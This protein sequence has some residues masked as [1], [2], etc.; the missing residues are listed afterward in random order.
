[1]LCIQFF[2]TTQRSPIPWPHQRSSSPQPPPSPPFKDPGSDSGLGGSGVSVETQT[3]PH[4]SQTMETQT[5]PG[6]PLS[7]VS[8]E[9]TQLHIDPVPT[10]ALVSLEVQTE[11]APLPDVQTDSDLPCF[12]VA[13]AMQN[14]AV[15]RPSLAS[16]DPAPPPPTAAVLPPSAEVQTDP[17]PPPS[18]SSAE[19]QTDPAPPPSFR[20]VE[21]P[22]S[23][24]SAFNDSV[25]V[26]KKLAQEKLSTVSNNRLCVSIIKFLC[27]YV[28]TI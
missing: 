4:R 8:M 22:T 14:K 27:I 20:S 2:V 17:A 6:P 3:T 18:F 7:F 16:T 10:P 25:C 19:V 12:L 23:C 15:L 21:V 26:H 11:P 5:D 1:M 9:V 28:D 24:Q 13:T